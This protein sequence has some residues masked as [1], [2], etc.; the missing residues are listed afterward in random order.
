MMQCDC[1]IEDR[2]LADYTPLMKP[3]YKTVSLCFGTRERDRCSCGGDRTKCDFYPEIRE[4]A[5]NELVKNNSKIGEDYLVVTY[6]CSLRDVP[7]LCVASKEGEKVQL[8]NMIQ[9]NRAIE[10]YNE[11]MGIKAWMDNC[12]SYI[13]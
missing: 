10:I 11:L 1:Y 12:D 2:Q 5:K 6:D 3:I 4:K 13:I 7:T 9:G 8:L